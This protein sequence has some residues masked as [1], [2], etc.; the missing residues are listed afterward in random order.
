MTC[1]KTE[2]KNH[3]FFNCRTK[4]KELSKKELSNVA[5]ASFG[6]TKGKLIT[7]WKQYP[8]K[9]HT[10]LA[11]K[12]AYVS[13]PYRSHKPID[14]IVSDHIKRLLK[15]YVYIKIGLILKF[16]KVLNSSSHLYLSSHHFNTIIDNINWIMIPLCIF[17][18]FITWVLFVL[19]LQ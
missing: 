3:L 10:S 12:S 2:P 15:E 14:N 18:Y 11:L 6:T 4:T 19:C 13:L 17:V 1:T 5:P 7:L 9:L 8:N 16:T